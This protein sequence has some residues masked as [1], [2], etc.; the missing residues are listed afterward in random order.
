MTTIWYAPVITY[1]EWLGTLTRRDFRRRATPDVLPGTSRW[2]CCPPSRPAASVWRSKSRFEI[3]TIRPRS[4]TS[5]FLPRFDL[6]TIPP[7][8]QNCYGPLSSPD[9]G[10]CE[11]P[12][13]KTS[14]WS[15]LPNDMYVVQMLNI[16]SYN[17][18]FPH[19]FGSTI[20]LQCI[21]VTGEHTLDSQWWITTV[22]N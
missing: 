2:R 4:E 3:S 1:N 9:G 20:I 13:E 10:Q 12:V 11:F 14:T 21:I 17:S 6:S 8:R 22:L 19:S 18:K 7:S 5:N 15:W 16:A